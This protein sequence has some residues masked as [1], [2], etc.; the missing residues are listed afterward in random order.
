MIENRLCK[1]CHAELQG[2]YCHTWGQKLQPEDLSRARHCIACLT[3]FPTPLESLSGGVDVTFQ[4]YW[5][6]CPGGSV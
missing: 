3:E 4:R 5:K 2:N 1:N 6:V